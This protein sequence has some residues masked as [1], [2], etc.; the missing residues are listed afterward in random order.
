MAIDKEKIEEHIKGLLIA[1]GEDPEREG[2]VETPTRVAKMYEEI[3][4]GIQ[5]TNDEI[6]T[7]FTKTFEDDSDM[8]TSSNDMVILRDIE[9][10]SYCEHHLALM[11]N[12]K[13]TVAYI[14]HGKVLGLSK[15]VRIVDMVGKRLQ[16]QER[17]GSD[18]A[19]IMQKATDSEDVAVIIEAQHAC[20]TTRGIKNTRS[21]TTTTT[22]RGIFETDNNLMDRLI[23][24]KCMHA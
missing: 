12:M 22:V 10:F 14:P 24:L 18:I 1:L 20:I 13:A 16:L 8:F 19:E 17:I 6:A 4:E 7:M 9:F 21:V 5:H 23:A 15:I 3:F 2:L 11:Y